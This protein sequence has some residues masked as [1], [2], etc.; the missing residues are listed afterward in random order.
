MLNTANNEIEFVIVPDVELRNRFQNQNR[1]P[2]GAKKAE[3]TLWLFPDRKVYDTT[4]LSMEYGYFS[5]SSGSGGRMA[6]GGEMDYSG[7]LN[8]WGY[9]L[10]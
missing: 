5:L 3:L 9:L 10:K 4:N 1:I 6:D 2:T 8:N 7:D